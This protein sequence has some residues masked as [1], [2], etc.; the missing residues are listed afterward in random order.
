[1]IVQPVNDE[2]ENANVNFKYSHLCVLVQIPETEQQYNNC[3]KL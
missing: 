1:M 2:K 3:K